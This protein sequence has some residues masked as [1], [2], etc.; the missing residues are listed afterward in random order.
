MMQYTI[1]IRILDI[2]PQ[3]TRLHPPLTTHP[4]LRF[5]MFWLLT[6][7]ADDVI[8]FLMYRGYTVDGASNLA[9]GTEWDAK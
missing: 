9:K 7:L 1:S 8:H 3:L 2:D 6:T 4:W 5:I